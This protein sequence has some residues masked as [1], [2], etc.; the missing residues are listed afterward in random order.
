LNTDKIKISIINYTNTLPFR[1][2]LSKSDLID[3]IE[4][5]EDIPS[6][7]AQK[8]KFGQVDIALVPVA[9]LAELKEFHL[10]TD[11]CIGANGKVDSVKLY[12]HVPLNEIKYITLDYQ[13]KSSVTLTRILCK[14]WWKIGP[15]FQE[16]LPG[17]EQNIKGD[18]AAV[19][20]GDRTFGLNGKFSYEFDLAEEWKNMTGLPFV[21]GAWVCTKPQP[22]EFIM[23]FNAVLKY[24]VDCCNAAI[25]EWAEKLPIATDKAKEYL[26]HR[27]DYRLDDKKREAIDLFLKHVKAL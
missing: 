13:S 23:E 3:K 15:A 21:F 25:Q 1:W 11:F 14:E 17:Y 5:H 8:L 22:E 10:L 6:I 9:L 24:G 12:S 4:L 7:C 20:I 18:N 2:A 16:A 26:L 27:I 19:V